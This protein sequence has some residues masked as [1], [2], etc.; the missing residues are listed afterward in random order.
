MEYLLETVGIEKNFGGIRAVDGS[1][2][3]VPPGSVTGLIGPNGAG[4]TT[5]FNIISGFFKPDAGSIR[6]GSERIEGLPPHQIVLKGLARTF[7]IPRELR[8]MTV[9]EN[10]MLYPKKQTGEWLW[11]TL[12]SPSRVR[13]QEAEI[14]AKAESILEFVKLI[15]LREE[16]AKNL[17]GGQKKLLEFA[18]VLMS[19]PELILLDEP[20]AGVN[21]TLMKQLGENI[22]ELRE[23]GTTFLL[24]EHDMDV[25]TRLCDLVVV[26]AK[27]RVLARG[28]FE[29]IKKEPRVLEAYL[30]G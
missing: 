28:K 27:G 2:V 6:F 24:I 5:L 15:H 8:E 3:G 14:R 16:P 18:R 23:R 25:I 30:A 12:F 29:E 4:K 19:D 9:L 10:M 13:V 1:S 7:Q 22:L 26:M 17:S 20:G 21:P 11:R